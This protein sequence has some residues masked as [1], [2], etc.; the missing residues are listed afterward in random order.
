MMA[1]ARGYNGAEFKGGRGVTQVEV[2]SPTIFNM[3]VDAVVQHWV[4]VMVESM[5]EQIGFRQ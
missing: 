5:E 3:M 2:L 4:I 1:K